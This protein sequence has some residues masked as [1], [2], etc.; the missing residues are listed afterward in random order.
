MYDKVKIWYDRPIAGAEFPAIVNHLANVKVEADLH[1][2]EERAFG[3]LEGLK[4]GIGS[5]GVWILGSLAKYLYGSNVLSLDRRATAEGMEKLSDELDLPINEARVLSMEF[6]TNFLMRHNVPDYL[7]RLGS[8]PRMSRG[9]FDDGSLY[10]QGKG[11]AKKRPKVLTFYDKGAEAERDGAVYPEH[12]KGQ[13]LLRYEMRLNERLPQRFNVPMV[14]ASTLSEKAFYRGVMRM[15]QDNYFAIRKTPQIISNA[16]DEIKTVGDAFEL[17]VARLIIQT[18]EAQI[19]DYLKELK[20]ANVFPD[21]KNY[22]RVKKKIQEVATKG[23]I[24][25]SD[26]LIKEL[27]DEVKN[28][29]AYV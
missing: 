13:N 15:Y 10:Y 17:F 8:M 28:C 20:E 24:T 18:G 27:D 5:R 7:E 19:G 26:E 23:N 2:G 4:V 6:G 1:T 21:R 3:Y 29:G 12:L 11:K 9:T 14:K 25:I 16:M 22:S